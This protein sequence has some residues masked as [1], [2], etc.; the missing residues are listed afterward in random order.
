MSA[1]LVVQA[2]AITLVFTRGSIFDRVRNA[3]PALWRELAGCPLCAGV[4]I[5]A[6]W[7]V[8]WERGEP[9]S[10]AGQ[11]LAAGA[12]AGVLALLASYVLDALDSLAAALD[13]PAEPPLEPSPR[14]RQAVPRVYMP[15]ETGRTRSVTP[16]DRKKTARIDVSELVEAERQG[17][18][19]DTPKT[20]RS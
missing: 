15:R 17:A 9:L 16:F 18:G 3:G 8:L 5:G 13:R 12:L 7:H 6:G 19:P 4:W 10:T 20:P 11:A 2:A 14:D 1:L